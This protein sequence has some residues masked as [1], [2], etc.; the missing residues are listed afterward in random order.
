[1]HEL[2]VEY[3]MDEVLELCVRRWSSV[4]LR[5]GSVS[6][7]DSRPKTEDTEDLR[8][9]TANV[10][11]SDRIELSSRGGPGGTVM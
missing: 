7:P 2:A 5:G 4:S 11:D 3:F 1:M 6:A 9:E 10:Y 8:P